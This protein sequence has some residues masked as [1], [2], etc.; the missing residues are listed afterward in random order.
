MAGRDGFPA[1]PTVSVRRVPGGFDSAIRDCCRTGSGYFSAL[2]NMARKL[3]K[4]AGLIGLGIIGSRVAAALR[5]AGFQTFVWNRT[6]RP[7]PNFLSS[8]AEVADVCDVIQ[9]FVADAQA[10]L[11]VID[12]FGDMLTERHTILCH[13][14]IGP[15]ATLE[16]AKLVELRG[17]KFLDAPFTGSKLAAEKRELTYYIGG[18]D[19][20][21][22]DVEPVLQASS[23]AI[24]KI[25]AIGQAATV[26]IAT[27]MMVAVSIQSLIE[28]YAVVQ[29]SGIDPEALAR[30]LECHGARSGLTDL[31]L[32]RILADDF[33]PHFS[34]KHMFKDAQIAIHIA[35]ALGIDI[36]ATTACAGVMYGGL[37]R[38]WGELDF[39]STAKIYTPEKPPAESVSVAEPPAAIESPA[40]KN[41]PSDTSNGGVAEKSGT[42]QKNGEPLSA[43]V[44]KPSIDVEAVVVGRI[45]E[46]DKSSGEANAGSTV[47]GHAMNRVKRWFNKD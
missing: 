43:P 46:K 25:G 44:S 6:P 30:A 47:P 21:L 5:A 3:R 18:S 7:E 37:S 33:E 24:V 20:V 22:R 16:A 14:T 19:E 2:S 8:P 12:A 27:N 35:N 13:A 45:G 15:E 17:A 11:E 1:R 26:K 10:L 32:P 9:I 40:D 41:E 23:K 31:K 36:P 34:L 38:G 28:A 29:K 4:N 39:S 42:A